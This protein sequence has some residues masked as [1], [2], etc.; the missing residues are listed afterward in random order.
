MTPITAPEIKPLES[1]PLEPDSPTKLTISV[2]EKA[3]DPVTTLLS[4]PVLS[5]P[6]P[7]PI[8]E[9]YDPSI[10]AK[11]H[12]PFYR[13]ATPSSKLARLTSQRKRSRSVAITSPIDEAAANTPWHRLYDDEALN[14]NE[15]KLW[16]RKKRYWDCLAGLS[17]GQ[18]LMVKIAL[19]VVIVGSMVAVALGITAGV[20]GGVWKGDN[21]SEPF[22]A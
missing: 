14:R 11:P 9:D 4:S 18:R 13:H 17:K 3:A 1:T 15:S 8:E 7:P 21:Q 6:P 5:T 22:E 12:S 20:G 2:E 10:G 16:M 19:A